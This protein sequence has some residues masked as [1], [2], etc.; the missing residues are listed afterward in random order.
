MI[1]QDFN[2]RKSMINIKLDHYLYDQEW[3]MIAIANKY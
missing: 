3:S 2:V 1:L